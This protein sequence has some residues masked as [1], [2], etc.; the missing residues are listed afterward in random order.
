MLTGGMVDGLL[1]VNLQLDDARDLYKWVV[2]W[3]NMLLPE[4]LKEAVAKA[5][6][7]EQACVCCVYFDC[8]ISIHQTH[9]VGRPVC[10]P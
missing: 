7:D 6:A 3:D 9:P 10:Q 4:L 2:T 5:G 1:Q 8:H